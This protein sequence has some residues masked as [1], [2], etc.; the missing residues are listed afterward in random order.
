MF[1]YFVH[2]GYLT[3]DVAITKGMCQSLLDRQAAFVTS[4]LKRMQSYLQ[5]LVVFSSSPFPTNAVS[6]P[7]SAYVQQP[8]HI[9]S[10]QFPKPPVHAPTPG[11]PHT[12][13]TTPAAHPQPTPPLTDVSNNSTTGLCPTKISYLRA[14]S[15]SREKFASKLV[16]ELFTTEERMNSNVK[17]KDEEKKM[18][19]IRK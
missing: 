18:A 2:A 10:F 7:T 11:Q 8:D 14:N 3:L 4:Q 6:T 19:Y 1:V 5:D 12:P 13:S 16:K 17:R 15:C 9:Q